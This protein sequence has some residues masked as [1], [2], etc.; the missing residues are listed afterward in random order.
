MVTHRGGSGRPI[1]FYSMP[2]PSPCSGALPTW[3]TI[4]V[5]A[6]LAFIE[7]AAIQDAPARLAI[8]APA[9]AEAEI[10]PWKGS[11]LPP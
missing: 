11:N 9:S 8:R 2:W 7:E 3:C 4:E 10:Q 5:A 1:S 6:L